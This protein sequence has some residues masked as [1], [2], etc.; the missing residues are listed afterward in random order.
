MVDKKESVEGEPEGKQ[1]R[2]R[3]NKGETES[4][5]VKPEGDGRFP[6]TK[7]FHKLK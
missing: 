6:L 7:F 3:A 1:G 4:V 5:E 2:I